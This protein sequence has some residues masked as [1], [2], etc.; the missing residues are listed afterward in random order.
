MSSRPGDW[1]CAACRHLNFQKRDSCHRC[2]CPKYAAEGDVSLYSQPE[3][4]PGDWYCGALNCRAHNYASRANCYRCGATKEYSG[5]G[6]ALMAS[7]GYPDIA[8][9]GWKAGDWICTRPGCSTHNYAS[10]TEC[11]K[12][13]T[14][15]EFG[16]AM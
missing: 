8:I 1:M 2:C 12:C 10:R 11:Y 14:A 13:K 3:M 16:G 7:A 5:Y 4:L 9:P 15:R 6:A